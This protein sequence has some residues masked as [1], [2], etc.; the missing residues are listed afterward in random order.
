ML[1]VRR[2]QYDVIQ[3]LGSLKE[4]LTRAF[5]QFDF[6]LEISKCRIEGLLQKLEDRDRKIVN[7]SDKVRYLE[8]L[9]E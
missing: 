1:I 5:K 6:K 8:V 4:T 2:A 9:L 7:M 3:N